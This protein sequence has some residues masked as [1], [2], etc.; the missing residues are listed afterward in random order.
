[1]WFPYQARG[2]KSGAESLPGIRDGSDVTQR[3]QAADVINLAELT[4]G[5]A[6]LT[7]D[8]V[9]CVFPDSTMTYGDLDHSIRHCAARLRERGIEPGMRIALLDDCSP[10]FLSSLLGAARIGACV[11]PIH[12][13]LQSE[14]IRKVCEL[15]DCMQVGI[16]GEAHAEKLAAALGRPVLGSG[17]LLDAEDPGSI[18]EMQNPGPETTCVVLLTSG[19]TGLPKPIP[20]SHR[21][22][23][24]RILGFAGGFDPERPPGVSLLCLPA[25]HIGGLAGMLV[26][27]AGGNTVLV[28][29]RFRSSEWLKKVAEH[30]VSAAFLVPTMIR[31]VLDD[32]AFDSS[33]LSSLRGLSY[34]AA[35]APTSTVEEMIRRFPDHVG[36]ANVYGQTE[37]TGAI[38]ALGPD[39]HVLDEAGKLIRAGSVGRLLPGVEARLVDPETGEEVGEGEA[40]ELHVRSAFNA[41]EGWNATGDWVHIDPDG[42]FHPADRLSDTINRGGEKFGPSEIEEVLRLHPDVADVAV[43]GLPDP[44]LG[45]RVGAAVVRR[46]DVS[47]D[48]LEAHCRSHL[49]RFKIPSDICFVET[50]PTSG[51]GKIRRRQIRDLILQQ[52]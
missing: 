5:P 27:I 36:F 38:T 28:M 33:D 10:L 41:A 16:A 40:G 25:V 44:D 39:D 19:T 17:D 1:M 48:A 18:P 49:A 8:R 31:R 51:V 14:E 52:L 23:G 46:G 42:Y 24:P 26:S 3:P 34:G 20:I 9:A 7:P 43:A 11:V 30:R 32:P 2:S 21:T 47:A 50:I 6:E 22:F 35:P 29:H 37:T 12:S 13:E 45:E 4:R 15:A